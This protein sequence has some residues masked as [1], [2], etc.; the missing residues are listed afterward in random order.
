MSQ[1][2]IINRIDTALAEVPEFKKAD[3][4]NQ[5]DAVL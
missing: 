5:P 2:P 4:Q 1:F 3:A